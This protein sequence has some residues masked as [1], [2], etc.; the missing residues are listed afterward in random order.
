MPSR[1]KFIPPPIPTGFE[2]R[3]PLREAFLRHFT[4]EDAERFRYMG[5]LIYE[6]FMESAQTTLPKDLPESETWREMNAALLD[7]RFVQ[8]FLAETSQSLVQS[9][10]EVDDTQ[11]AMAAA[12]FSRELGKIAD[13]MDE[14]L[15]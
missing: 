10:L 3:A 14:V 5:S 13:R 12:D 1:P 8:H 6:A 2:A 7:L 15:G 11:L 9:A 4:P